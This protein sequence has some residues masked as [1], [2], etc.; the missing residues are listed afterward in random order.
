VASTAATTLGLATTCSTVRIKVEQV[1][2]EVSKVNKVGTEVSKVIKVNKVGM[3]VI[4]VN[5]VGLE[6]IEVSEVGV[7][8]SAVVTTPTE[9][10]GEAP[11]VTDVTNMQHTAERVW[12]FQARS[13]VCILCVILLHGQLYTT[14]YLAML[15]NAKA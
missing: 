8:I 5:K 6:V 1:V 2:L 13:G 14:R 11:A 4:K 15:A 9:V 7:D 10:D 12:V 3:E